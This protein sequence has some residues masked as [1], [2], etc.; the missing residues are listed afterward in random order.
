MSILVSV[1]FGLFGC[2]FCL[3]FMLSSLDYLLNC[4]AHI[5]SCKVTIT[6]VFFYPAL[7]P[8]MHLHFFSA[9]RIC[10]LRFVWRTW[11]EISRR[12]MADDLD[13]TDIFLWCQF[14]YTMVV[15]LFCRCFFL[16]C[17]LEDVAW[18]FFFTFSTFHFKVCLF[19][20]RVFGCFELKLSNEFVELR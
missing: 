20:R 18:W 6:V 8:Y 1:L 2:L 7:R 15:L 13:D 14:Q 4:T 3:L 17:L 12:K 19:S 9:A 10:I 5:Y 16:C 11:L